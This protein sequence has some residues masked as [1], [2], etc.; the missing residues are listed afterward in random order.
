MTATVAETS[1]DSSIRRNSGVSLWRQISDRIR[2]LETD[3]QLDA[4]GRLP[5]EFKLAE[6]FG[7][8]RHTVRSAISHLV[9]EGVLRTEQGRGT[10]F[11][12]RPRLAY[13]IG[14]RTRFSAGLEGQA[15]TLQT[16]LVDS[17]IVP[18]NV[19]VAEALDMAPEAPAVW[20][21]TVGLAD[22]EPVSTAESWFPAD[23]LGGIADAF[24]RTGSITAALASL[25]VADYT[26]RSTVLTAT[27]AGD[28]D[29]ARLKLA[30]GA[31]VL[32]TESVNVDPAGRP[33]Q[34]SRTR[35]SADR[36]ELTIE[37]G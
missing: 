12:S 6:E 14:R 7:V 1:A 20:L 29:L 15:S 9:Q 2:R 23:R 25:G 35:F 17:A 5:P 10:F 11:R 34:Y 16:A 13:P 31:I 4:E 19:R 21:R 27:H 36:I 3:G 26:R 33:I 32:A 30:P 37:N 8:N 22:G 28:D 24:R 18:A